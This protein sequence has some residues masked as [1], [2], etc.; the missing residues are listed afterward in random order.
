MKYLIQRYFIVLDTTQYSDVMR[1]LSF[2]KYLNYLTFQISLLKIKKCTIHSPITHN[3]KYI[4][5]FTRI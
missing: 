3:F 4:N 5:I 2:I 1:Y